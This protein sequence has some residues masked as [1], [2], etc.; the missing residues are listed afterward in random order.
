VE[1]LQLPVSWY[2]AG[3]LDLALYIPYKLTVRPVQ[4]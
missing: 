3:P 4:P 2:Q 1:G